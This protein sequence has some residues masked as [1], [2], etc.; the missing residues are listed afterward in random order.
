[1]VK[2]EKCSEQTC[3]RFFENT[4]KR[5]PSSEKVKTQAFMSHS[6]LSLKE[7]VF[8]C[9]FWASREVPTGKSAPLICC[10]IPISKVACYVQ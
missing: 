9:A 7:L 6:S 8:H 2:K 1:M 4:V 5:K 10:E 3:C